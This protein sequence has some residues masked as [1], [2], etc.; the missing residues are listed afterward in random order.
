MKDK[1]F[2]GTFMVAVV[3]DGGWEERTIG[4]VVVVMEVGD[5]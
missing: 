1:R 5:E 3:G 4:D 2:V